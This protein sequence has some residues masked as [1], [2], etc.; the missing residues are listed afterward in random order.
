MLGGVM[1]QAGD[2]ISLPSAVGPSRRGQIVMVCGAVRGQPPY[3]VCFADGRVRLVVP[4][5]SA[6]IEHLSLADLTR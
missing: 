3:A 2:W 6:V 4:D 5:A 1:A